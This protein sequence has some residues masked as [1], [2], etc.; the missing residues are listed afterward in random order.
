MARRMMTVAASAWVLV[1]CLMIGGCGTPGPKA[2]S[3]LTFKGSAKGID[4]LRLEVEE[5]RITTAPA[6]GDSVVVRVKARH[7]VG[8]PGVRIVGTVEN[9]VLVV[10][11]I[12]ERG[13]VIRDGDFTVT[14]PTRLALRLVLK[15]GSLTVRDH[16]GPVK[17][18]LTSGS[19]AVTLAEAPTR[20]GIDLRNSEGSVALN[21]PANGTYQF[22]AATTEGSVRVDGLTRVRWDENG[23]TRKMGT[24][25][26]AEREPIPVK[27][28]NIRG[29]VV[30]NGR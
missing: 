25:G 8:E 19:M 6:E 28:Y 15:E 16:A 24:S 2:V 18:N 7:D 9:R 21:L 20:G 17:A 10:K 4:R 3:T 23:A 14:V 26:P 29:S 1:L 22:E 12:N 30:V 11:V 5:G 27:V 13:D